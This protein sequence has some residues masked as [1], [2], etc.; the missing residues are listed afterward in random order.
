MPEIVR[1]YTTKHGTV[2]TQKIITNEAGK[3]DS[4]VWMKGSNVLKGGVYISPKHA[5]KARNYFNEHL[6]GK[7]KKEVE[8]F[9]LKIIK[10]LKKL[11]YSQANGI[12]V[13]FDNRIYRTSVVKKVSP[14]FEEG[15]SDEDIEKT[16]SVPKDEKSGSG[17]EDSLEGSGGLENIPEIESGALAPGLKIAAQQYPQPQRNTHPSYKQKPSN[18]RSLIQQAQ[19]EMTKPAEKKWSLSRFFHRPKK[20]KKKGK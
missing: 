13:F 18:T 2:Y 14:G 4:E 11:P 17:L 19:K 3:T 8:T 20:P 9:A 15:L 6:A 1:T 7:N 5:D 16:L 12:I 10:D